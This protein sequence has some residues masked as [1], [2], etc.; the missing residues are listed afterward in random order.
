MNMFTT[1]TNFLTK[2][3]KKG[4]QFVGDKS[5]ELCLISATVNTI[6]TGYL[7]YKAYKKTREKIQEMEKESPT[8]VD[9]KEKVKVCYKYWIPPM[10]ACFTSLAS[11]F[12]GYRIQTKRNASLVAAYTL[13]EA[14]NQATKDKMNEL[15][16]IQ[17]ADEVK[18]EVNKQR[19]ENAIANGMQIEDSGTGDQLWFDSFTGHIFKASAVAIERAANQVNK[20]MN[21]WDTA[22]LQSFYEY[23]G[24]DGEWTVARCFGWHKLD[25]DYEMQI[26]LKGNE[27]L[28]SDG[29][30]WCVLEY[31]TEPFMI[32]SRYR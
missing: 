6:L 13:L 20:E 27:V 2:Y 3:G 7:T 5:P 19:I 30:P 16:G 25:V 24:L 28:L 17:K 21:K 12:I 15:L 8:P 23:F 14:S 26:R 22:S 10:A 4:L 9:T 29:T 1:A 31:I 32:E 18:N 11:S